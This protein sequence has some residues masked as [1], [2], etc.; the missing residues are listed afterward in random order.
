M[1]TPGG[2]ESGHGAPGIPPTRCRSST[3]RR[4]AAS[5]PVSPPRAGLRDAPGVAE[6]ILLIIYGLYSTGAVLGGQEAVPGAIALAEQAIRH[7]AGCPRTPPGPEVI[8]NRIG[9]D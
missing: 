1:T 4:C 5:W 3:S 6:R 8:T 9:Q 7:D 2:V